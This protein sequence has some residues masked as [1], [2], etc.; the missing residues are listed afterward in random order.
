MISKQ[1][2]DFLLQVQY[3]AGSSFVGVGVIV[4]SDASALPI[5]SLRPDLAFRNVGQP[6]EVL[7]ALSVATSE[8]HDGFHVLLP[9]YSIVR[10][11][12]YFGPPVGDPPLLPHG[13]ALGARYMT[14]LLG[15]RLPSVIATG[16]ATVNQGVTVFVGGREVKR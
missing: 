9:D 6:V 1:L 4:T 14:A 12:Q 7:A 2:A 13:R 16:I 11:A 5:A 8:L 10:V 15:S 3:H